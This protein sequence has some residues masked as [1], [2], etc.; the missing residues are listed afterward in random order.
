MSTSTALATFNF[1]LATLWSYV[2]DML[3]S[4]GVIAGVIGVAVL[5]GGIAWIKRA[6]HRRV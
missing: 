3:T 5:F 1:G 2:S 4:G 6:A